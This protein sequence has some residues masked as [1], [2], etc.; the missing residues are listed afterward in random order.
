MQIY[1]YAAPL[2][3]TLQSTGTFAAKGERNLQLS[4]GTLEVSVPGKRRGHFLLFACKQRTKRTH[5]FATLVWW[6]S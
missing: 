5:Y 1:F 4:V 2:H 3:G 6:S